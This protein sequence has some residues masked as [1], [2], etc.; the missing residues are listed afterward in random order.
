MS[1]APDFSL[2]AELAATSDWDDDDVVSGYADEPEEPDDLV[3]DV[4]PADG[5]D[6]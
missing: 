5:P 4:V 2:S 3:E 6:P 1:N